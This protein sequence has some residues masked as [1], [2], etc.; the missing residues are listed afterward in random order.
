MDTTLPGKAE[1][2]TR[3]PNVNQTTR[4][5]GHHLRKL[6]EA[7]LQYC[8]TATDDRVVQV[9]DHDCPLCTTAEQDVR[10][11]KKPHRGGGLH[12]RRYRGLA[13]RE[14][15]AAREQP[16]AALRDTIQ[17][18][19]TSSRR[20]RPRIPR[21]PSAGS[22]PA[23]PRLRS[24]AVRSHGPRTASAAAPGTWPSSSQPT[25]RYARAR[26]RAA[27]RASTARAARARR[28]ARTTDRTP[29]RAAAVR[30]HAPIFRPD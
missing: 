20:P 30:M 2:A 23:P 12:C 11:A 24:S 4:H 25:G 16:V 9:C 18:L 15:L 3:R 1:L 8:A 21:A 14:P 5:P 22:Q 13:Q 26:A 29:P 19:R 17:H 10:L 7:V 27:A 6:L 28:R